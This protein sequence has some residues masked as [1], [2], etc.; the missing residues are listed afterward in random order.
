[1]DL[2][3]D[4]VEATDGEWSAAPDPEYTYQWQGS[5]SSLGEDAACTDIAGETGRTYTPSES[6][7]PGVR[8]VVTA[9]NE[10]GSTPARSI[11]PFDLGIAGLCSS[12]TTSS[13]S[14]ASAS[15]SE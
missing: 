9:S 15:P 2:V 3:G 11:E 1:M 14:S 8:V 10:H 6:D 7:C 12:P 4:V 13:S 5:C